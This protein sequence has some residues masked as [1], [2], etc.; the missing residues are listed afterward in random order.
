[1]NAGRMLAGS[2]RRAGFFIYMAIAAAGAGTAAAQEVPQDLDDIELVDF[3]GKTWSL[4]EF[5]SQRIVVVA[6]LGTECPLAKLYSLT[7]QDLSRAY[8]NQDVAFLAVNAN[9]QDSLEK[10]AAFSRRQNLEIPFIKDVGQRL[11]RKIGATRT[12]EVFVLDADRRLRYH[13][14]IDD[15]YGIGYSRNRADHYYLRDAIDAL[16]QGK[17]PAIDHVAAVGCLISRPRWIDAQATITYADQVSRILNDHCVRCHRPGQIGP[18]SL[19]SY[20]DAAGWADMIAEVVQQGRMPPWTANPQYGDFINDCSLAEDERQ[21]L[22]DWVAA[23]APQGETTLTT[24]PPQF[25]DGWQLP[26]SPDLVVDIHTEPFRVK[27][28]GDVRYQYF[29]VDP[30]F[31]TDRWVSAAELRPGNLAVVHHI[32]CFIRPRGAEGLGD[33]EG[34]DGFLAGYVPGMLPQGFPPGYAKRIPAGSEFV[35]QVHYTPIGRAQ[36]DSSVMGLIFTDRAD[37]THE[38][39]T[40]SAV[41]PRIE[42]PPRA[43][44]HVETAWN[45]RPLGD[46]Q[47]LSLMPHMHLR[48]KAFRYEAFFPDGRRETLLDVPRF[49]FNWQIA[50][51]F[52]QPLSIPAG[53]RIFC[54]AVYDNS[55]NNLANP[56]PAA[57]VTWGDQT[58]EEMMIGYFDVAVPVSENIGEKWGANLPRSNSNEQRI[59]QLFATWDQNGDGKLQRGEVPRRFLT[60][61]DRVDRDGQGEITLEQLQQAL[62]GR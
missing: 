17:S 32:L 61:F 57:R 47:I 46:W 45:R 15:Q 41:N 35:F 37:V 24:E 39:I 12:P 22:L 20:E 2:L 4:A 36:T 8:E 34:L 23:G 25:I 49:D 26:Q 40:T 6:F 59:D 29:V 62:R 13:G 58:W 10:M 28:T 19:T 11:M 30:Q 55:E 43:D 7:L 48:G 21:A 42:I 56:D 27:A 54:T 38:V 60:T 31:D 53:T 14:R 5:D 51:V 1:M 3:R 33:G 9:G 18:F 16:L 44:Q 50:Y 52:R